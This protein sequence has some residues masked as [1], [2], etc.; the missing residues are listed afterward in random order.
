[1]PKQIK[2]MRD[3]LMVQ[4]QI[5]KNKW[6]HMVAV[7]CLNL[8]YRKQVKRVLPELFARYPDHRSFI[9]GN[10]SKQRDILKDLGMVNVR[11][12]R[13]RR[14][15][16]E[17]ASWNGVDASELHGIGKYGSDSYEIFFKNNIPRGVK[18]KQL[19]KYIRRLKCAQQT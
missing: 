15:S 10:A 3:D 13:I 9:R 8:T 6:R 7:M 17:Y 5:G 12:A 16:K 14:M 1:M 18:D 4:Q 11:S 2:P 19:K